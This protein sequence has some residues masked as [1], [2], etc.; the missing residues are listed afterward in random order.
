MTPGP[1]STHKSA[2]AYYAAILPPD[3]TGWNTTTS[4]ESKTGI[5]AASDFSFG[6]DPPAF[7]SEPKTLYAEA[8]VGFEKQHIGTLRKGRL[9]KAVYECLTKICPLDDKKRGLQPCT[10]YNTKSCR[11]SNIV[12]NAEPH[13]KYATNSFLTIQVEYAFHNPV[14]PGLGD[15]VVSSPF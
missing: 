14:W 13:D 8:R 1:N 9:E 2:P 7:P 6:S 5:G 15:A 4:V 3:V 10:P 11:V 12:Y